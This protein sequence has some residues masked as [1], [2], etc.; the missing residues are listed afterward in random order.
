MDKNNLNYN[1]QNLITIFS[2][3]NFYKKGLQVWIIT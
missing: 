3:Q 2:I 1:Y